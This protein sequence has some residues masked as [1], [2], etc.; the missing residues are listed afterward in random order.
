VLAVA[1]LA[2]VHQ[3]GLLAQLALLAEQID[4]HPHLRAQNVRIERL[5][6]VV[7]RAALVAGEQ[8]R[9]LAVDR[10]DEDDRH[11]RGARVPLHQRRG[12]EPVHARHLHVEQHQRELLG[13]QPAQRLRPRDRGHRADAEGASVASSATRFA[14]RSS[15]KEHGRGAGSPFARAPARAN[16]GR[17]GQP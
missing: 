7:D 11:V 10:G 9:G 16:R 8:V 15:T 14:G 1:R 6:Q 4:E 3:R 2:F 13:Q 12:L 17:P 5:G